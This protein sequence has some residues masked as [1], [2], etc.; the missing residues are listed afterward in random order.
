M[1][2]NFTFKEFQNESEFIRDKSH[3]SNQKNTDGSAR[4][5]LSK[6]H[7]PSKYLENQNIFKSIFTNNK[8]NQRVD[9]SNERVDFQ[10]E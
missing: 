6:M 5:T 4:R 10:H 9:Y 3:C 8:V 2:P 7:T 1:D